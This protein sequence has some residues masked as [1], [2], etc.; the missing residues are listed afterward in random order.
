MRH[1]VTQFDT[2]TPLWHQKYSNLVDLIMTAESTVE[3]LTCSVSKLIHLIIR[4]LEQYR[5]LVPCQ[6]HLF[7]LRRG[8]ERDQRPPPPHERPRGGKV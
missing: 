1:I 5:L 2:L 3:A 6:I 4:F 8:Q 7:H